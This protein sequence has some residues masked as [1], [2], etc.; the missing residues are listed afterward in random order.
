LGKRRH[1][2]DIV[3]NILKFRGTLAQAAPAELAELTAAALIPRPQH[4]EQGYRRLF[5]EPFDYLDHEFIPASPSQGPFLELLIHAP[6]HGL[7]LIHRLVDHAISF[8][9][10]GREH[11]ADAFII[12]FPDGERVFP[13]W[14]SYWW[15]RE[16]YGPYSITS[17]LMALEAWAHRRIEEGEP[18]NQVLADVLGPPG[19]PAAYLLVAVD[20]LLSHWPKSLEAAVPFLAC[21]ELLCTDRERQVYDNFQYPDFFGLRALQKEPVSAVSLESLKRRPSRQHILEELLGQYAIYGPVD[22]RETLTALLHQA[23]AR[24]GPPDNQSNLRD[25]ALM[26]V[27]ALN[28]V[29]G[30]KCPLRWQMVRRGRL[31]SMCLQKQK[32][33]TSH[34]CKKPL[35]ISFLTLTCKQ[36]SASHWKTHP[37]RLMNLLQPLSSGRKKP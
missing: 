28:L 27:H 14:R 17:A 35:G 26:A 6:E 2:D 10:Q 7:S 18:L 25:P 16:G 8:Y 19:F 3:R 32:V 30:E 13:W 11:G 24:L 33:G 34:R 20:L 5:E 15:S 1:N 9:S 31:T 36:P 22:L 29:D 12:S 23:A 37:A 21:P 4:E